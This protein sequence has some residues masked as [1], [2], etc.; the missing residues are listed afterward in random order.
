MK[1][2]SSKEK[3]EY[4]R[5]VLSGKFGVKF[6]ERGIP[7]R[8]ADKTYRFDLVSP[9]GSIVGEVKGGQYKGGNK[10][11]A[12]ARLSDACLF[13]LHARGVKKRLLVLTEKTLY[14]L[15]KNERQGQMAETDGIEIMLV[16][17]RKQPSLA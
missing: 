6:E 4:V 17:L 1:K 5:N 16:K 13:L 10:S 15:F 14:E 8:G 12:L 3:E 9:D 2:M 7:L 11:T